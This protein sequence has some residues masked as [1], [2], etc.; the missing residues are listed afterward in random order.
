MNR[1]S[2]ALTVAAAVLLA[3]GCS[4]S[5]QDESAVRKY[6]SGGASDSRSSEGKRVAPSEGGLKVPAHAEV[7]V[8]ETSGSSDLDLKRFTP[9]PGTY[10]I[11]ARCTGKGKVTIVDLDRPKEVPTRVAC[12][13][14]V[15]VGWV[16]SEVEAQ[17]LRM[18]V[19]DGAATWTVA[20]VA[21][22]HNV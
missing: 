7:L 13:G 21:G 19:R 15:T 10:T 11:Y 5:G 14:V 4:S 16:Y 6:P 9:K 17:S 2:P 1:I 12:D 22:E 20:I 3:A 8:P 18:R